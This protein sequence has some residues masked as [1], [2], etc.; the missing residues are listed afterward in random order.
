MLFVPD[1]MLYKENNKNLKVLVYALILG[2][3]IIYII[4]NSSGR[5]KKIFC[6]LGF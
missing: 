4:E 3:G 1:L 6:S 5:S 2:A